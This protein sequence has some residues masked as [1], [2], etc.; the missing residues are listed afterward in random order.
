MY[1]RPPADPSVFDPGLSLYVAAA[2]LAY[3]VTPARYRTLA[4]AAFASW[5]PALRFF[6]GEPFVGDYPISNAIAG[7]L[8][9]FFLVLVL[10]VRDNV[11]DEERIRRIGLGLLTVATFARISE[12]HYVVSSPGVFAPDDAWA[13]IVVSV[14]PIL[15][16]SE[17]RRAVHDALA[18]RAAL[19]A[20]FL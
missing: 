20:S 1:L 9:L 10:V 2:G 17:L 7:I 12:R 13:L 6:S 16:I 11:D 8:A 14:L 5:T 15:A 19:A 4:V 18:T 3:L